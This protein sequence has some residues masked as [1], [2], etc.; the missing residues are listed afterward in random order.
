VSERADD[1]DD[2]RLDEATLGDAG[3]DAARERMR[4]SVEARLSA[5]FGRAW[6]VGELVALHGRL[7]LLLMAH[8]PATAK[9]LGRL[10]AGAAALGRDEVAA[11]YRQGVRAALAAPSS[12]GRHV[13]ALEHA[14]GYF[15][16]RADDEE[17]QRLHAEIAAYGAGH[18]TLSAPL[19]LVR[20]AAAR[21][22]IAW[23][24]EQVY[25]YA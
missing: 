17:R 2:L 10:V 12:R 16:G 1:R 7:K 14:A 24:C 5:L 22:Q 8:A 23:L 18:A 20:Q 3:E 21:H 13:N 4:A 15:R 25:L 11:Q 19:A 6:G 9:V